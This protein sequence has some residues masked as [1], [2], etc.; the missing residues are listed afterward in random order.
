MIHLRNLEM[1][2]VPFML[3]W[4]H[5]PQIQKCF[6]KDMMGMSQE[7][8]QEFC[9]VSAENQSKKDRGDYQD[10]HYAIADEQDEYLGT[11]SLKNIDW[12]SGS[13]EYAIST[14]KCVHGKGTA[15]EATGLMLQ[16]GFKE[17]GLHRIYL[18][19]LSDNI[20]AVRFYEKCGFVYEGEFREHIRLEGTLKSLK[21]FGM[22]EDEFEQWIKE[23]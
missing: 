10:I 22:L 9:R 20:R 14:R 2:D 17:L 5:D 6:Q 15:K 1:K 18:N 11:I 21:W 23:H 13:A 19:V 8:A 3:E 12:V 7:D 16:K 4:M